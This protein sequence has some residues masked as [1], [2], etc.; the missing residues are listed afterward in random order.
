MNKLT[1]AMQLLKAAKPASG[2]K[3]ETHQEWEKLQQALEEL[4]Y[5]MFLDQGQSEAEARSLA[6]TIYDGA[7]GRLLM[8]MSF[9]VA[10]DRR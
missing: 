9:G 7:G 5:A 3:P 6:H 10:D 4:S 1:E 8:E 2:G